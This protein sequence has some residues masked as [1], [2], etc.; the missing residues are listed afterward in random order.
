VLV[1]P[2]TYKENIDFL[3]KAITVKSSGGP[4]VTTIATQAGCAVTFDHGE[5]VSSILSGLSIRGG[6]DTCG[7]SIN[8]SSPTVRNNVIT[9]NHSCDGAGINVNW[10]SPVIQGNTISGNFHDRCSGGSGGAGIAVIGQGSAQIIGNLISKNNGGNGAA[11]GGISLFA[12]GTPIVKN[13]IILGNTIQTD[14]G[15]I[16]I[17]ACCSDAIIV[18]NLIIGNSASDVGGCIRFLIPGPR[19]S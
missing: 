13:N 9:G 4:N 5:G 14:G 7:I 3:G 15:G 16:G 12:A 8:S 10:G 17:E 2:G 11:G 1:A 18:Q 19:C 6:V